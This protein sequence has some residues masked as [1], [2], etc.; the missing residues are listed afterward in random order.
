MSKQRVEKLVELE[1]LLKEDEIIKAN[2][3]SFLDCYNI[4]FHHGGYRLDIDFSSVAPAE[5]I[6]D[7]CRQEIRKYKRRDCKIL[8]ALR[9]I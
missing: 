2:Y 6:L 1:Q 8:K 4:S 3:N 5:Y 7:A 9:E